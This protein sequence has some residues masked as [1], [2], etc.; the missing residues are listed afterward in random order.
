MAYVSI[1]G[2]AGYTGQETLDR[3][4][5]HPDLELYAVGSDSLAGSDASALDPRLNRN[6]GK[7]VPRFITNQAALACEADITFLCLSH[8]E[9]ASLEPP[10]RG[11]VIDLSGAHRLTDAAGYD[12]WY[13]FTHPRPQDLGSWAY[14]LPELSPPSGRL[15][16][17]P[18]CY[19]TAILL[20]LGPV[21]DLVDPETV[22]VDAMSGMTGAGRVPK[23][24]THAGSVLENVAP[25]RVGRHQHV[26]EVAQLLGFPVSLTPH[27]LPLRRGLMATCNVRSTGP[28]LR[29]TL[30]EHYAA[31]PVVTVLPEGVAPELARVQ[32]T[33]G[34]ELGVFT[35]AYT[36]RTIIVCAEDN[37]GK[38]AAGQAVQNAN[39]LFGLPETA[40]LRL[41]GVLV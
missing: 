27:L 19:A 30:E 12:H 4:L 34:A 18:G 31:S 40:G 41:A 1:I 24:S 14:G 9:A 33:D 35:D 22:V 13:G 16:A 3:V 20:A 32:G 2:A 6:G 7:R 23:D 21:K 29:R 28:D 25:Y 8:E 36:G 10:A 15:I 11:V 17:N 38:G 39:L 37:L 5:R 26:A